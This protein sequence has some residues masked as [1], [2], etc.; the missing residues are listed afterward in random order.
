MDNSK[1][2]E[3][4]FSLM[5]YQ[6]ISRNT[7]AGPSAGR[8]ITKHG[9]IAGHM[10][11]HKFGT[12]A[13]N[14]MSK[15]FIPST[16]KYSSEL[17][18]DFKLPS[19]FSVPTLPL[20]QANYDP[21]IE[22][23]YCEL[24]GVRIPGFVVGGEERLCLPQIIRNI[25]LAKQVD[26]DTIHNACHTLLIH[27]ARCT[28]H[29]LRLLKEKEILPLHV[30]TAGLI[31]K[32]DAERLCTTLLHSKLTPITNPDS[33]AYPEINNTCIPVY[34]ECFG[35]GHGFFYTELYNHSQARCISCADCEKLFTPER[36]ITHSHYNQENEVIHWGFNRRNWRSYL[37][38]SDDDICDEDLSILDDVFQQAVDKFKNSNFTKRKVSLFIK[39]VFP[40]RK[41]IVVI[42]VVGAAY[43]GSRACFS[44]PGSIFLSGNFFPFC[45]SPSGSQPKI[46]H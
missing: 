28:A 27:C 38:L 46:W 30:Q 39:L 35:E 42:P 44:I 22:L 12:F 2:I 20:L 37:L 25:L 23:M 24:E 17:P 3:E 29:Q 9:V 8:D 10:N 31:R 11:N 15:T 26:T 18:L 13:G 45:Y 43:V 32:T 16:R 34:H 41:H 21:E 7:L 40:K 33:R 19:A 1:K 14:Q 5:A 6:Q 36:F 4:I